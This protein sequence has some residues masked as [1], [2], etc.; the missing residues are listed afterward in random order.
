MA[1]AHR[2]LTVALTSGVLA[3]A[4]TAAAARAQVPA[5]VADDLALA[6]R[7]AVARING[8]AGAAGALAG[9]VAAR[10]DSMDASLRWY[11]AAARVTDA[12][13]FATAMAPF[14]R[15]QGRLDAGRQLLT[16]VLAL[17]ESTDQARARARAWYEAGALAFRQR[18]QDASRAANQQSLRIATAIGDTAAIAEA[19]V[20]LSRVELRAGAYDSVRAHAGEASALLTRTGDTLGAIGP[21]H[22]VAAVNRMTGRDSEAA[23]LY[24]RTL[25]RYRALSD[26]PGIA[27]E[28]MNLGYVRLHQGRRAEARSLFRDALVRYTAVRDEVSEEFLVSAFAALAA[29]GGDATRAAT[30]YGAAGNLLAASGVTLDPDDQYELDRYSAKARKKLGDAAYAR[31]LDEGKALSLASALQLAKTI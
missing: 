16:A 29:D 22:M 20:G 9:Q 18:D 24:E 15:T 17:P 7:A 6:Q 26:G 4:W 25:A 8:D 3:G 2:A 10:G 19:L 14:W 13:H 27:G 28:L 31:A 11:M 1:S 5:R 23:V 30:L 21:S 12:L